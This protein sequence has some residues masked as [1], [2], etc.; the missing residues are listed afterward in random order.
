MSYN[1]IYFL[2]HSGKFGLK[3]TFPK[4]KTGKYGLIL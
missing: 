3:L 4:F 1:K 2:P